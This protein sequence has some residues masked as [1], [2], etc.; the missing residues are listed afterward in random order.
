M[1]ALV[2]P[3]VPRTLGSLLHVSNLTALVQGAALPLPLSAPRRVSEAEAAIGQLVAGLVP[4]GAC[5]EAGIGGT[6]DAACAALVQHRGLGIHTELL[7]DGLAL[8]CR[9]GAVTNAGKAFQPGLSV[10]SFAASSGQ[11]GPGQPPLY[12]WLASPEAAVLFAE[13]SVTNDP[14]TIASNP[15]AVAIQSAVEVALD[16][17]VCADSKGH[18]VVSGQGGQLDFALGALGSKGGLSIIA[19][20]SE[21]H[22]KD[23]A[24]P[25][26]SRIVAALSP[27]AGVT[28]QR[29][30]A[31]CF[32]TEHGVARLR[33]LALPGRAKA[34]IALAAPQHR[35][36]LL[37]SARKSG[38]LGPFEA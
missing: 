34:L 6:A 29:S 1:L 16:G 14:A 30:L 20:T 35:Q 33:G 38:V 10:T 8:L 3:L 22:S 17:S 23:P 37:W 9:S 5:I 12:A 18:R 36:Q 4:D 24:L 21:V 28:V 26:A 15:K 25:S 7:S 2:N 31:D 19:F 32:V 27:G 13:T 11:A